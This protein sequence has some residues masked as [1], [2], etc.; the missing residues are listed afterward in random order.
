MRTTQ[1]GWAWPALLSVGALAALPLAGIAG[2]QDAAPAEA[3][4][5]VDYEKQLAELIERFEDAYDEWI[6][7]YRAATSDEERSEL[8][9]KMPGPEFVEPFEDLAK[10]AQG[11]D[12]AAGAWM[13]VIKHASRARQ[14]EKVVDACDTLL[15]HHIGSDKIADLPM[16]LRY[17]LGRMNPRGAEE[18]LRRL[19]AESPNKRVQGMACFQLAGLIKDN[20]DG[21]TPEEWRTLIDRVVSEFGDVE[22]SRGTK[23]ADSARGEIF[24][25]ERLQ[26]GMEAPDIEGKDLEGVAFKLS[27]YRGKVVL[28]DF[29][30]DW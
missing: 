5:T 17:T 8:Y 13:E 30:G 9:S 14:N 21:E 15:A 27:D 6:T 20:A 22:D 24:E 26:V 25:I 3:A 28:L 12:A 4:A 11:T 19:L 18:G 23:I 1:V 10:A 2:A 29:W 16:T 7:A